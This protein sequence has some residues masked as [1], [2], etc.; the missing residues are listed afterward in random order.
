MGRG[1]NA[2][3][4]DFEKTEATIHDGEDLDIPTHIR[5]GVSL[6]WRQTAACRR[7]DGVDNYVMS[8]VKE[9]EAAIAQLDPKDVH[10]VADWVQ[11][12]REEL[13]DKKIE[14]DAKAGKLDPLIEKAR[15]G[16]R[17]GKS[18]PFP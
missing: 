1:W 6:N 2:S 9:I 13:W 4:P 17:A 12:Y 7:A 8:T 5:R 14:V 18:T 15:A 16:H 10:A 3:L 11:E